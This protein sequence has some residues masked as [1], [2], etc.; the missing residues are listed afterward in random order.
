MLV[1]LYRFFWW[2]GMAISESFCSA[3]EI[4]P[5]IDTTVTAFSVYDITRWTMNHLC[6]VHTLKS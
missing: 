3:Q 1:C 5:I 4:K 6:L 2:G